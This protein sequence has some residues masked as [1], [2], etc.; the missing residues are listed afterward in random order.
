MEDPLH[1]EAILRF[2]LTALTGRDC[3]DDS[4]KKAG[5]LH[6]THIQSLCVHV[7]VLVRQLQ[8]GV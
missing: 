1:S 5:E 7:C 2:I 6:S 8:I 3:Y 4:E